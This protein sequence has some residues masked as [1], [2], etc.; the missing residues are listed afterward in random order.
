MQLVRA[1]VHGVRALVCGI[2]YD[3]AVCSWLGPWSMELWLC[4]MELVRAL[5]CGIS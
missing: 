2:S 4:S 1:L 3:S 5:V